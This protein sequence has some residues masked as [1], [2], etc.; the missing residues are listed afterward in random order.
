[1]KKN[2]LKGCAG[3]VSFLY[4][5]TCFFNLFTVTVNA[6]VDPSV[7]TYLIQGIAGVFIALGAI[8]TIFRHK[9]I[10][11]FRKNKKGNENSEDKIQIK[12]IEE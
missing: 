3:V 10:G 4:F 11:F 2:I 9:I 1:M 8:V 5:F 7:V 6:Y 12:D